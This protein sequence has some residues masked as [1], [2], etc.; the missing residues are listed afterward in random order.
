MARRISVKNISG[1]LCYEPKIRV[2]KQGKPFYF[3][4][5]LRGGVAEFNLPP[6]NYET[7]N[8]I[9]PRVRPVI[10][11]PE[12]LPPPERN[13]PRPKKFKVIICKNP[14]KCTIELPTGRI[15]LDKKF[16]QGNEVQVKFILAH[17]L[18]HYLYK[19][20]HLCDLYANN[21]LLKMGY[22]PSQLVKTQNK[23]LSNR[24]H[25][26]KCFVLEKN[27]NVKMI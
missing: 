27:F 18:G 23:T 7:D 1:F 6:G 24:A 4:D 22:N 3:K 13:I 5:N 12:K 16:S 17:E 11:L 9:L 2:Y 20:E 14:N 26:R 25:P 10:F 8:N 21:M 15:F 19:S